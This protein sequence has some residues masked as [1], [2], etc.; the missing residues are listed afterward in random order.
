M[1]DVWEVIAE[2]VDGVTQNM[3]GRGLI[4]AAFGSRPRNNDGEIEE[5]AERGDTK[6][7]RCDSEIDPQKV[8]GEGITE[9]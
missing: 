6:D 8:I 5:N 3:G 9:K 2:V 4:W 1:K 7:N